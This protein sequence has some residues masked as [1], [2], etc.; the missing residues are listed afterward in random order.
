MLYSDLRE[1]SYYQL[2]IS[3]S[4]F[5]SVQY[6]YSQIRKMATT[7]NNWWRCE[8][9]AADR[10]HLPYVVCG[11]VSTIGQAFTS[12]CTGDGTRWF[13]AK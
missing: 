12:P 7:G 4:K 9:I 13:T 10:A 6:C 1:D 11:T 8:I 5:S 3:V 2:V